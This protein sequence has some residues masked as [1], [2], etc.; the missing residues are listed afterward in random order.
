MTPFIG[1]EKPLIPQTREGSFCQF[2]QPNSVVAP[3]G[4][5]I[6]SGEPSRAVPDQSIFSPML[7]GIAPNWIEFDRPSRTRTSRGPKIRNLASPHE[8]ILLLI[9]NRSRSSKAASR[10]PSSDVDGGALNRHVSSTGEIEVW[11]GKKE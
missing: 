7:Q 11:W 5:K 3:I 2:A 1:K 10:G 8:S 6:T 9:R 4:P